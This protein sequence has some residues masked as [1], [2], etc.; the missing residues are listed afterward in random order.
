M[1]YMHLLMILQHAC[2]KIEGIE[3][4]VLH[5]PLQYPLESVHL[6]STSEKGNDLIAREE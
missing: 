4:E 1:N 2:A 5:I 3:R 6:M